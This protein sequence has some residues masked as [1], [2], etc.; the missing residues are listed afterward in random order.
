MGGLIKESVERFKDRVPVLG[1]IPLVGRFFRS[2]GER[3]I[4]KNLLIFVTANRIDSTGYR[5]AL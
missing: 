2:E 1:S 3:S 5:N 4:K